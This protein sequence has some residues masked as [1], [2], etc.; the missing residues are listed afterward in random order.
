MGLQKQQDYRAEIAESVNAPA[1]AR[2]ILSRIAFFTS[3]S[4]ASMVSNGAVICLI[5]VLRSF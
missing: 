4:C 3:S 2:Y 1:T 5:T